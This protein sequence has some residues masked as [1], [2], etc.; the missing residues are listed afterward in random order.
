[1]RFKRPPSG[2]TYTL[3]WRNFRRMQGSACLFGGLIYAAAALRAWTEL[4]GSLDLKRSVIVVFPLV[5][6]MLTLW[7]PLAVAPVRRRLKR[8]VWLSFVSGFGQSVLSVLTG[9]GVLALGGAFLFSEVARAGHGGRWPA[10]AFSA[11][12]S[13]LGVL[14]AQAILTT[15]LE[16]E[17]KIRD[18]ILRP[19]AKT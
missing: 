7:I 2:P 8:Y 17:P 15:W 14:L 3:E 18:I 11:L 9:L 5:F 12:G 1:M 4:E 16:H 10:G 13:G 6:G 19:P